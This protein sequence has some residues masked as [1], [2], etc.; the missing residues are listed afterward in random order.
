MLTYHL[1]VTSALQAVARLARISPYVVVITVPTDQAERV[2]MKQVGRYPIISAS[3]TARSALRK[4]EMPAIQLVV[5]PPMG[6]Q[7]SLLLM[8]NVP[9]PDTRETWENAL[10][11]P[12]IWRNY[13]LCLAPDGRVTWRLSQPARERYTRR[14]DTLIK[15]RGAQQAG[16]RSYVPPPDTAHARVLDLATHLLRYPGLSGIRSDVFTLAQYSTRIWCAT[17]PR[18]PYPVWPRMPYLRFTR[19]Q[20]APLAA[21]SIPGDTI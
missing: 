5:M 13:A 19:P 1:T 3:H 16:K 15:G 9:P 17:H 14:L 8:S 10:T 7:V 12:L 4:A 20:T 11:A 6:G 18:R 21:L 2:A